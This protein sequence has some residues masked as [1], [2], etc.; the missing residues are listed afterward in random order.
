[1]SMNSVSKHRLHSIACQIEQIFVDHP[2][3]LR[4]VVDLSN[5]IKGQIETLDPF[6][7]KNTLTVCS[8]CEECCCIDRYSYYNC[9]DLIYIMALDLAPQKLQNGDDSGP[10]FFLTDK[11]CSLDRTVRP[12]GCNWYFCNSLY[13]Q[14]NTGQDKEFAEFSENMEKLFNLWIE[15]ISQFRSKFIKI[16]DCE[17]GAVD[18]VSDSQRKASYQLT[19]IR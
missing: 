14:M 11:G 8:K 6:I 3:E 15:L 19:A 16:T 10:C 4:I 13:L 5:Q 7:Q 12:S 2:G 9:D 1:M 17:L 18:L